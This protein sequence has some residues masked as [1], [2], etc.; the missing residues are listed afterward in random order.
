MSGE[1]TLS[2]EN[3]GKTVGG[4][5]SAPNPAG[6]LTALHQTWAASAGG[7]WYTIC[8]PKKFPAHFARS[9]ALYPT[10]SK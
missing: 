5:G 6:E 2:A 1:A 3:S 8:A 4:R 7:V 9:I 10:L